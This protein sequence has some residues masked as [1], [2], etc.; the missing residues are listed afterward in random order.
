MRET[1]PRNLP[2]LKKFL[3]KYIDAYDTAY[4]RD[5]DRGMEIALDNVLQTVG[6]FKPKSDSE[7]EAAIN[8]C[9]RKLYFVDADKIEKFFTEEKSMKSYKEFVKEGAY[10]TVFS[11]ITPKN[12]AEVLEAAVDKIPMRIVLN[13]LAEICYAKAEHI[14]SNWQD[15]RLATDWTKLGERIEK[16]VQMVKNWPAGTNRKLQDTP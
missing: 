7:K 8:F 13:R 12:V 4:I 15:H 2:E 14:E 6:N 11:T 9:M 3:E 5:D 1:N 10:D 16:T